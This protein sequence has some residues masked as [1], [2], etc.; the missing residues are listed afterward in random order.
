MEPSD[1]SA[2]DRTRAANGTTEGNG[3]ARAATTAEPNGARP[4]GADLSH[5]HASPP[6]A[7]SVGDRRWPTLFVL[8]LA[9]AMD[10]IDVTVVN[11]AIPSIRTDLH[12]GSAETEWLV[13]SY[14]LAF[15]IGLITGG[16]LGDI[17]GRRR[18]F[19]IGV[20]GF[21]LSSA[22]CGLAPDPIVLVVGRT[23]QGAMAALMVPQVLATLTVLFK[24]DERAKAFGIYGASLGLSTVGGPLVGALLVGG[25]VLGLHWRPIFLVNLLVGALAFSGALVL[26]PES[27]SRRPPRLDPLGVA[28]VTV[29]LGLLLYPLVQGQSHGWPAWTF[30][31][32][33]G[34]IPVFAL[35]VAHQ[36][37]RDRRGAA[38]IPL[39]MLRA[40]GLAGS[41][42][43]SVVFSTGIAGFS[44]VL[45]LT[46]QMGLGFSPMHAALSLLPFSVGIVLASGASIPLVPRLGRT[47]VLYGSLAMALGMVATLGTVKVAGEDLTSA[48][49]APSMFVCGLGMGAVMS[50]IVNVAL[51][52]VVARDSGAASGLMTT[53]S[54]LGMAIGVGLIGTIFFAVLPATPGLAET[55]A[56]VCRL[57]LINVPAG[58]S[59]ALAGSIWYEIGVFALSAALVAL[60]PRRRPTPEAMLAALDADERPAVGA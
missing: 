33:A 4:A 45:M 53:A 24:G 29:A 38:L 26:M 44:L 13:A 42:L 18:M 17:Y 35:L 40:P 34:S 54:Q 12:A 51:A 43:V 2:A 3:D 15:S 48:S 10:L 14:T 31:M 50:T 39:S 49:L 30:A 11:V 16:R 37:R 47:V 41:V 22:L 1:I 20:A 58:Y 52:E 8:L 56:A 55:T 6:P 21:S 25:D 60:M 23:L 59:S 5:A 7:A 27:R 46:L 36:R 9:A 32:M 57:G 28:L 19:L